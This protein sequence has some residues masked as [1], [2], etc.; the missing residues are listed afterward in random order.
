MES[1]ELFGDK[2]S[3][4]NLVQVAGVPVIPGY[5]EKINL[6]KG[7]KRRRKKLISF[8]GKSGSRWWRP[9]IAS[10]E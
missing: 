1:I 10:G 4:K 5:Q 8:D 3:A 9:W 7:F 6:W 2:I